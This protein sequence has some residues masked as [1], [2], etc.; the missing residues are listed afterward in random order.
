[1]QI[2]ELSKISECYQAVKNRDTSY[3]GSF[4]FGVKTTGIFCIPSCRARTPKP[5]NMVYYTQVNELLSEGYRPCKLCKPTLNAYEMPEDVQK[6]I[7]LIHE[8]PLDKVKDT[9]LKEHGISPVNIR[10]WFKKHYGMTF[11][12]YQ[13]MFRINMAFQ[14]LKEGK[15]V[16]DSA[17]DSGYGSLSGFAYTFKTLLGKQP[18][19]SK[20][21]SV[22]HIQR[23]TTPLGPMF[24][25]ASEKGVCLLEFADRKMLEKEFLHLQQKMNAIILLGDN[26]HIKQA[27]KELNEYFQGYRKSFSTPIDQR[28]NSFQMQYWGQLSNVPCGE[29]V[30]YTALAEQLETDET[31]IR[32]ANGMNK[33][34]IMVPCHR[35]ISEYGDLVGYGG[36]LE[37]KRWLIEHEKSIK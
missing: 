6:A 32:S 23:M 12:A 21:L 36:G 24:V 35:V 4:F 31:R 13:R 3:I 16:T 14:E 20:E 10:R 34:A 30:S 25:C 37:R 22:I 2:Q 7:R 18:N 11:Q 17:F 19:K 8:S 27:T 15:K 26:K 28:G 33:V 1:M 29:T 9:H 5:E